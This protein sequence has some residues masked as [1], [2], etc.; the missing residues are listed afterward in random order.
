MKIPSRIFLFIIS[1]IFI[2]FLYRSYELTFHSPLPSS[3]FPK[4]D[5]VVRR[6]SIFDSMQNELAISIDSV[7][8]GI[9]PEEIK[10]ISKTALL[11]EPFLGLSSGEIVKSIQKNQRK[12]FFWLK[13]KLNKDIVPRIKA[14]K[15]SGVEIRIEPSRFYPHKNLAPSVLGFVGIDN[16]G[17]A[18][19]EF[20]YNDDLTTSADNSLIG[21]NIHLT[22]NSL[23]QYI[24]TKNLDE[25]FRKSRSKNAVGIISEVQ[26]GKIL[27]MASLSDT[28]S[29]KNRA[30]SDIY[31]PGST[32][33]IFT[34]ASLLKY[35]LVNEEKRYYCPGYIS[36]KGFKIRCSEIHKEVSLPDIIQKSCNTGI[37]KAALGTIVGSNIQDFESVWIWKINWN[38]SS[39]RK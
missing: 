13:R 16:E 33:K 38:R 21:N 39:R 37:I 1:L 20:Q 8:I 14:L 9:K 7:S 22:M 31:E 27:A 2:L 18:G 15:L 36:N 35:H 12:S 6:G 3:A 28:D 23:V 34:L 4:K 29:Y 25:V 19:L 30:V 17:L 26:T 24:L 11:L 10:N 32:F 5:D